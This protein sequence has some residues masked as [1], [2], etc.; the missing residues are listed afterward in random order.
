MPRSSP[1]SPAARRVVAALIDPRLAIG[2]LLVAGSGA[3]VVAIVS[4]ADDT[5]D[6]YLAPAALS[7]G[8]RLTADDLVTQGV[9][10]PTASDRYLVPGEIPA[11]GLVVS[12]PVAEGELVPDSAVGAT[13]SERLAPVVV[14]VS[15]ALAASIAPGASVD[16]WAAPEKESGEFGTPVVLV[17]G[18]TVVRL[19][20]TDSIVAAGDVAAVELLVP[21][22]SVAR[23]L[24]AL[25]NRASIALVPT[26]IPLGR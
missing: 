13:S 9:R 3:G 2:V 5:V 4:A 15:G 21:K 20:S 8:D 11:D 22:A 25:A 18:A 17:G 19:V 24:E 10:V 14:S 26:S 7:P 6:V 23:V 12:R 1:S 16:L